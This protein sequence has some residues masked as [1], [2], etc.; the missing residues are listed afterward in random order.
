M[1]PRTFEQELGMGKRSISHHRPR[2]CKV[3]RDSKL[4]A[5]TT[6]HVQ[7]VN[8]EGAKEEPEHVGKNG[9]CGCRN[10][11]HHGGRLGHDH[12]LVH[13]LDVRGCC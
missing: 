10:R 8:P 12:R 7:V 3:M 4:D 6:A 11:R 9:A 5:H 1:P 2:P 13:G